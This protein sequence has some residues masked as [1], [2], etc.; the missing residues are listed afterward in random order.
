M[1]KDI[2]KM[3][4]L[5]IAVDMM[6]DNCWECPLTDCRLPLRK[7]S[8]DIMKVKYKDKRHEN[9]LLSIVEEVHYELPK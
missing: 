4:V 8:K 7:N 2:G 5:Y 1:Q 6:P 3:K 9:C